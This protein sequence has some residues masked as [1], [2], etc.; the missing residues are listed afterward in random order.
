MKTILFFSLIAC[1]IINAQVFSEDFNGAV[2]PAGWTVNNPDTAFNW[3]VGSTSGF[4]SFPSGAAFFDDDNAGPSGINTNA[5]LV[6]PVIN[7]TAVSNPKLSFKYANQ[8]YMLNSTLKVEV[9]NGTSWV[10]VFT[11]SGA[12]GN[13]TIDLSTLNY[14][15]AG[16]VQASSINLTPYANANFQ[17]RFVYDDVGDYSF[18][19]AVDDV[20]ITSGV[21]AV[22]EVSSAEKMK[23]YPNPV[24]NNLYINSDQLKSDSNIT[25]LDMS[26]REV[27]KFA[28]L[29]DGY[30]LSDLP[31][32]NYLIVVDNKKEI[33]SK[34]ITKE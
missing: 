10:Q 19:V 16:Y 9:F 7:L 26:G 13:W 17:L 23:V 12:S 8:I 22:S 27:K 31:K 18:G 6:S 34:K 1:G 15:L 20:V 3:G 29:R 5:R 32:G 4:A 14:V 25:V 21:L 2:M 33:I 24:K 28:G 30:D 11:S